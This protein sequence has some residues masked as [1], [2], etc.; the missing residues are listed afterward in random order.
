MRLCDV[1][2]KWRIMSELSQRETA[3]EIG[4]NVST[5]CRI[6]NGEGMDGKTLAK[7]LVWLTEEARN[8]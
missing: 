7:V 4:I 3:K 1:L 5:L 8:G 2:R 6:E